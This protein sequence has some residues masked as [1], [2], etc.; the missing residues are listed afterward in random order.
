LTTDPALAN[1]LA[2]WGSITIIF[3]SILVSSGLV[4]LLN[5]ALNCIYIFYCLD[6]KFKDMGI[7]V[8]NIP[9]EIV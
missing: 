9:P 1:D 7:Q 8:K 5:Q 4:G 2:T 3:L 6:K